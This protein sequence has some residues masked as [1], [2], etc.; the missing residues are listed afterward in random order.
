MLVNVS[1]KKVYPPNWEIQKQGF[2]ERCP[3]QI[4][5]IALCLFA[6]YCMAVENHKGRR[7]E[8]K[9]GVRED[10]KKETE[11]RENQKRNNTKGKPNRE[12]QQKENHNQKT[13]KETNGKTKRAKRNVRK[14]ERNLKKKSQTRYQNRNTQNG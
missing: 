8:S 5:H 2:F 6:V 9:K 7:K 11:V 10:R 13:K 12:N 1:E 3:W 4:Q 14:R